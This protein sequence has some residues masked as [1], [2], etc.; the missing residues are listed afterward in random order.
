[1]AFFL[2]SIN[3]KFQPWYF[4]I[5]MPPLIRLIIKFSC[6]GYPLF[7]VSQAR[8]WIE[9][10]P[11]SWIEHNQFL[12]SHIPLHLPAFSRVYHRVLSLVLFSFRCIQALSVKSS[13]RLQF[14]IIYM[15][16]TRKFT[17][18]FHPT[19]LMTVSLCSPP[20]LTKFMPGSLSIAFQSTH[21]RLN[22]S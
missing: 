12:F 17:F 7:M 5:C 10:L 16:M 14:H 20:P 18:H 9:L 21:Q 22:S 13:Q 15:L 8:H 6:P 3:K 19:S 2:Q 1:M 4:L 11:N